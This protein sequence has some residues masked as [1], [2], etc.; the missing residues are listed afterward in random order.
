MTDGRL[1]RL[2]WVRAL[3]RAAAREWRIK[4]MEACQ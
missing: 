2:K 1:A 4:A 3:Y